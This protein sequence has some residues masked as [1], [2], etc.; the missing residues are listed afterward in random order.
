MLRC[1]GEWG[2]VEQQRWTVLDG[3]SGKVITVH[4]T[5]ERSP[6]TLLWLLIFVDLTLSGDSDAPEWTVY[7]KKLN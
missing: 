1:L 4:Y 7:R 3:F 6:P 2:E 5:T